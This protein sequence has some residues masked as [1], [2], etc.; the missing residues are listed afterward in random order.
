[1]GNILSLDIGGSKLLCGIVSSEGKLLAEVK[2][3]FPDGYS[4]DELKAA[5]TELALP[6]VSGFAPVSAGATIPGLCDPEKGLWI[7]A[8]KSGIRDFDIRGFVNEKFGL[9]LAIENDVNACAVGEKKFGVC[10][11]TDDF[12]WVTVSTGIGG[13]VFAN[14]KLYSGHCGNAGEIG[15]IKV[16]RNGRLC[17]C[18]G[19]GC[20]EAEASGTAIAAKYLGLTGQMLSAKEI[21]AKAKNGDRISSAIYREAGYLIGSA[22]SSAANLL[23]PEMIVLGG[24]V[25]MDLELLMPGIDRALEEGLF[26]AANPDLK[27]VKTGLG[28]NAALLG[29]AALTLL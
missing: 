19:K 13:S 17:G 25:A 9:S 4:P 23:N 20:L 11:D 29:A 27:I 8:P 5:L 10:R 12:I 14:G 3:E 28:Y 6:L 15:H 22:L 21:A 1:M 18:G 24:G 26:S 16:V 2:K 7:Y